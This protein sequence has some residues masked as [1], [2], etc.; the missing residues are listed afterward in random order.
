MEPNLVRMLV[1]L[2]ATAALTAAYQRTRSSAAMASAANKFLSMLSTDQK[3][4]ATFAMED[5]ERL[6]WHF[7]PR[8]RKG[9]PL[10]EMDAAQRAMAEALLS[11]GLSQAGYAKVANIL[12]LEP[13]LKSME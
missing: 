3:A 1:V 10:R 13:V 12:S 7:I 8:E 4:K 2:L 9:L 5:K 11:S 6:N